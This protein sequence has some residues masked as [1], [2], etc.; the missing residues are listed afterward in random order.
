MSR[1]NFHL[2]FLCA[3]CRHCNRHS[4]LEAVLSNDL[5]LMDYE[6]SSSSEE[7]DLSTSRINVPQCIRSTI[8]S[9]VNLVPEE[10]CLWSD[11]LNT[12]KRESTIASVGGV[13]KQIFPFL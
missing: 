2:Q 6:R 8:S 10:R 7:L 3:S 11:V 1:W 4:F 13:V 12:C 5:V 9:C